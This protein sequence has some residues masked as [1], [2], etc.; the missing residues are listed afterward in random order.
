M[1][2]IKQ[3]EQQQPQEASTSL[4]A[5]ATSVPYQFNSS[6]FENSNHN[7]NSVS[8]GGSAVDQN[9]RENDFTKK[10]SSI[11]DGSN[12][13]DAATSNGQTAITTAN[14]NAGFV[15]EQDVMGTT[16]VAEY[17]MTATNPTGVMV[18]TNQT[19]GKYAFFSSKHICISVGRTRD[20][21]LFLFSMLN[22]QSPI[23]S[24]NIQFNRSFKIFLK[25]PL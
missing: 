25:I 17:A 14:N 15:T 20:L 13:T 1:I 9:F 4:Y 19:K 21:E 2:N 5:N 18:D 11:R 23:A 12:D 8:T 6:F 10:P 22:R 24:I 16:G 7:Q 3:E